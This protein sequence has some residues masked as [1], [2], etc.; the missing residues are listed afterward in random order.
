MTTKQ[1]TAVYLEALRLIQANKMR[2]LCSALRVA[3][4]T[5][6]ETSWGDWGRFLVVFP[7]LVKYKP[8][9][10]QGSSDPWWPPTPS[11]RKRRIEVLNEII[12]SLQ[13]AK[14]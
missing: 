14:I 1:K 3:H 6:T 10:A 11:G 9:D 5:M 8:V 12:E 2:F 7:E 13:M 4:R